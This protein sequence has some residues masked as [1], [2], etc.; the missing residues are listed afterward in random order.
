[1]HENLQIERKPNERPSTPPAQIMEALAHLAR[2][3]GN[4]A[5]TARL[6]GTARRTLRDWRNQYRAEYVS[7]QRRMREA[8]EERLV[9]ELCEGS[10]AATEAARLAVQRAHE[11]LQKDTDSNPSATAQRLMT[12]AGIA[13]D[14][15]LLLEG[16]PT[17]IQG[18]STA[19]EDLRA[20][21]ARAIPDAQI[22]DVEPESEAT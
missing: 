13:T 19:D 17:S 2:N 5:G 11:R 18:Q 21:R 4:V 16:R 22:V 8:L 10:L 9:G 1:M 14:K 6:T 3:G 20:L 7:L 12:A 15:R